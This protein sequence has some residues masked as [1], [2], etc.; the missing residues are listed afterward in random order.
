MKYKSPFMR[1]IQGPVLSEVHAFI[2]QVEHVV[3]LHNSPGEK[4]VHALNI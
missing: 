1:V 3:R 4:S 2:P